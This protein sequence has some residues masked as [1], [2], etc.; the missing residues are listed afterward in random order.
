MLKTIC[1]IDTICILVFI[2]NY[3]KSAQNILDI[4]SNEKSKLSTN[5][6]KSILTI[7]NISFE[8]LQN[9]CRGYAYILKNAGFE[10][11][12]SQFQP[13]INSFSPIQVRISSEYLWSYG[14]EKSW[15]IISNWIE[16]TFG[17]IYLNKVCR[18][19]LCCHTSNIDFISDYENSYKGKFKKFD[20]TFHFGKSINCI[21]FGSRK[22][23][24]IYCRIYNKT[25]EIKETK[26]KFWFFDIWKLHGLDIENVWNLEFELKSEFLRS[27]N[28]LTFED[29]ITNIPQLWFYCTSEWLVK[30]DRTNSRVNR[31]PI[32]TDWLKIQK[33]FSTN[34][35]AILINRKKQTSLDA[36][37][38]IPNIIGN[39]TSF[40]ARRKIYDTKKAFKKIL[41]YSLEYLSN[42]NTTFKNQVLE[43]SQLLYEKGDK[44]YEQ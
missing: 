22:G 10:I 2:E 32:N 8:L 6:S 23:K 13:T 12:I 3:E 9:G 28:I 36:V 42:K 30:I 7:N 5:N 20:K 34:T 16:N 40:C 1:N 4:L 38:L 19:D 21:T 26:K 31:C 35:D 39:I 27:F 37:A 15:Q 17:K 43:K 29:C 14:A 33:S 18:L 41:V 44:T 24:N 25:L 11:K